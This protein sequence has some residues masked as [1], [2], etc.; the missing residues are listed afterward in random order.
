LHFLLL[1]RT[2][3]IAL[4]LHLGVITPAIFAVRWLYRVLHGQVLRE[5]AAAII[6]WLMVMQIMFIYSLNRGEIADHYQYLAIM[7]VIYSNVNQRLSFRVAVIATLVL[8]ASYLGFLI[9]GHSPFVTKF[10][11]CTLV[12]C[13]G[14]LSLMANRRMEQDV[15]QIFLGRL[16]D[17]LRREGAEEVA[18]RDTLTGLSNRRQLDETVKNLWAGE[19]AVAAVAVIMLDIDHFKRFNDS[20]GHIAGD[21]CLKRV[22]A[23]VASELRSNSDLAVRYGG[24]EF[25]VLMP[26]TDLRTAIRIA[27]R[28]RRQI[29]E[30]AIPH[31]GVGQLGVVTVS[32]G[33]I[34]GPT[35]VHD[36]VELVAA[37]DAA[38]YAAKHGGRNQVWPPFVVRANP[39][40][41]LKKTA[42]RGQPSHRGSK[43]T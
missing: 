24:E 35:A 25:L 19:A 13:A 28:I 4:L 16:R 9:P 22:A 2:A 30:L 3:I 8:A 29:E 18:K 34:A 42:S 12:V 36:F 31:N 40:A 6:P 14:Y 41:V 38:L 7:I 39:V 33:V 15:R 17:Q 20:Y 32:L 27:E 21:T 23:A 11:G 5:A 1:P 43:P 37:A 26:D 10:I